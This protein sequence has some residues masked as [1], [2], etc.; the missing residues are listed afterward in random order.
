VPNGKFVI[1]LF[2]SIKIPTTK[3]EI[4]LHAMSLNLPTLLTVLTATGGQ[5]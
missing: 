5:L 3:H 4:M 1:M 2:F